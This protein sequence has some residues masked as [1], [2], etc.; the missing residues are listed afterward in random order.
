MGSLILPKENETDKLNKKNSVIPFTIKEQKEFINAIKGN[1]F[2]ALFFTALNSGL[3]EGELMALT[4]ND[5]IFKDKYINVNKNLVYSNR[6]V[7]RWAWRILFL[8][9][10]LLKL[11]K[12]SVKYLFQTFLVD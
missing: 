5:I 2:E 10:K 7:K 6:S 4:W 11:K 8:R 3:R 12:V 9:F 1:K